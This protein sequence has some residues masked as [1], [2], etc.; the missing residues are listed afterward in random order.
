MPN[1]ARAARDSSSRRHPLVRA[2]AKQARQGRG[3]APGATS[4]PVRVA[5][6]RR[7]PSASSRRQSRV[8]RSAWDS[9]SSRSWATIAC[10]SDSVS[11]RRAASPE[12]SPARAPGKCGLVTVGDGSSRGASC[13]AAEGWGIASA[14]SSAARV[15]R[16]AVVTAE[17]RRRRAAASS[18][19]RASRRVTGPRYPWGADESAGRPR[20]HDPRVVAV[21]ESPGSAGQGGGQLPP[22]VT[23]GNSATESRPPRAGDGP[24][25]G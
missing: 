16:S 17:S 15:V 8:N 21:E 12:P 9:R 10:I 13:G 11:S 19:L 25:Q 5:A 23:R 6:A 2:C 4:S 24:E 1:P 7:A 18:A 14:L 3:G 20:R 22:G